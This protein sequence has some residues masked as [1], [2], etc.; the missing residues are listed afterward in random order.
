MGTQTMNSYDTVN[1]VNAFIIP[2]ERD[3]N[4]KREIQGISKTTITLICLT[5]IETSGLLFILSYIK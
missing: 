4:Q 3:D 2:A 1:N 5:L